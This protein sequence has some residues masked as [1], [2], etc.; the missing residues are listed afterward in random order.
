MANEITYQPPFTVSA[1]A[2][3]FI[4][5]ISASLERYKILMEGPDGIRLR[6][7][8]HI[9]TLRGTTAIEGNTLTEE[10]IT[11][12]LAGKHILAPPYDR[13]PFLMQD[14]FDWVEN[15]DDHMLIKSC[16]FHY[17]FEFIH[18]F[19]DGNGRMGRFWQTA[20]L[21]KWNDLFYAAP[22]ENMIFSHQQSYYNAIGAAGARCD[23]SPFIDFM[24]DVILQTI[25]ER[26]VLIK[27]RKTTQK[28][29]RKTTLKMRNWY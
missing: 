14:L 26:G 10:E 23:A 4:G 12:I 7:A 29:T 21:G 19:P 5:D 24:L 3:K 1:K 17:E 18:P 22:V 15:A 2:I 11:T 9:K 8:N 28:T 25:K 16:V 6:K 27:R 13:V 20:I